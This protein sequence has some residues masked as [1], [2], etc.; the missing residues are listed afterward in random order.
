MLSLIQK[1]ALESHPVFQRTI[2]MGLAVKIASVIADREATS[3]SRNLAMQIRN[4]I[5]SLTWVTMLL[6]AKAELV[7]GELSNDEII[8]KLSS[9]N[10]LDSAIAEII[11]QHWSI[12]AAEN[13]ESAKSA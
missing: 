5:N 4:N 3:E 2:R 8:K 6:A 9:G 1:D 7:F 13:L 10:S 11:N 12:F